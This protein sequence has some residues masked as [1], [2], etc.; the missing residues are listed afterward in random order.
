MATSNLD[1]NTALS[2]Y[3]AWLWPRSLIHHSPLQLTSMAL[4]LYYEQSL[5]SVGIPAAVLS[6][7]SRFTSGGPLAARRT[8][9][10][11]QPYLVQGDH[12]RQHNLPQ[13]VRG[14]QLWRGT[15]CGV[16]DHIALT[17]ILS[18]PLLASNIKYTNRC[19]VL[20]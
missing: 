11:W 8:I 16:T 10:A 2:C 7:L 5:R 6:T 15:N 1:D 19:Y 4:L 14:D 3:S 9:H 17:S 12:L 13:M 18:P 20:L